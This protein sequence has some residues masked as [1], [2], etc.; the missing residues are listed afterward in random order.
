MAQLAPPL[1]LLTEDRTFN[2]IVP[3]LL[4]LATLRPGVELAVN[5][6]Q[7]GWPRFAGKIGVGYAGRFDLRG[8]FNGGLGFSCLPCLACFGQTRLNAMNGAES[9]FRLADRYCG[10]NLCLGA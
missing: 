8:Y 4:L 5:P 1:L 9:C 6:W 7:P 10:G 3:W 2:K